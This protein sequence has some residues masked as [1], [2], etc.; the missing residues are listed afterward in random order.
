MTDE[1]KSKQAAVNWLPQ[2]SLFAVH[3]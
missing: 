2:L 3:H 1:E